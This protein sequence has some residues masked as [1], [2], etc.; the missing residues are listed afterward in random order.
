MVQDG[1]I[2]QDGAEEKMLN[3][4]DDSDKLT[5]KQGEIKFIRS[6][7]N[8]DAKI[9]IELPDKKVSFNFKIHY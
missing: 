4:N 1:D 9:D 6:A 3:E 7:K 8:G 2:V 5:S